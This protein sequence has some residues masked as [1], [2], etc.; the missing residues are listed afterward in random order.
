MG[1]KARTRPLWQ[2]LYT[3]DDYA[4]GYTLQ[5]F[6][7]VYTTNCLEEQNFGQLV[8]NALHEFSSEGK[9]RQLQVVYLSHYYHRTRTPHSDHRPIGLLTPNL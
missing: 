5:F 3:S 6:A 8:A 7:S 9:D 1:T 2:H 4:V